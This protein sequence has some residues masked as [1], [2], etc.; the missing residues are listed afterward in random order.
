MHFWEKHNYM[1]NIY[2]VTSSKEYIKD[3][4]LDFVVSSIMKM[5]TES[6]RD[7]PADYLS[8]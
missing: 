6:M 7:G 3:A 2:Y 1:S 5:C 8:I 4:S